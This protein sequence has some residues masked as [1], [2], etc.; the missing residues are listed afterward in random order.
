M[1]RAN[2]I[3]LAAL[4]LLVGLPAFADI[5]A[6]DPL[7]KPSTRLGPGYLITLQVSINGTNEPELCGSFRLDGQGRL[8]LTI[9]FQPIDPIGILGVTCQDAK[10]RV[11]SAIKR[12]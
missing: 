4:G 12:F 6:L 9:G 5:G 7:A 1:A 11:T 2:R 10:T 8:R 3:L